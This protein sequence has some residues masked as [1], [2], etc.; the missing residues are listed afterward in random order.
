M[1]VDELG[2][3]LRQLQI[4]GESAC[5]WQR[6]LK[7]WACS[8]GTIKLEFLAPIVHKISKFI[9]M[10]SEMH[11]GLSEFLGSWGQESIHHG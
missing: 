7:E 10:F 3:A 1:G 2:R 6:Q 5:L 9:L 4:H 11:D 8:D